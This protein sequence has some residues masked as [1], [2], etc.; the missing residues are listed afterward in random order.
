MNGG[1]TA[2]GAIKGGGNG[3][4][5]TTTQ[6]GATAGVVRSGGGTDHGAAKSDVEIE[7]VIINTSGPKDLSQDT[8]GPDT[9]GQDTMSHGMIRRFDAVSV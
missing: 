8:M 1:D 7:I 4:I 2:L 9:L 6:N 3:V 5:G